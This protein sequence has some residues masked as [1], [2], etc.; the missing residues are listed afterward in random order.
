MRHVASLQACSEKHVHDLF[1]I[2]QNTR[3][4]EP[5]PILKPGYKSALGHK[6]P[7]FIDERY[8]TLLHRNWLLSH[9]LSVTRQTELLIQEVSNDEILPLGRC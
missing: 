5:L 1:L 6:P 2:T 4:M 7:F 3:N 9:R 8:V